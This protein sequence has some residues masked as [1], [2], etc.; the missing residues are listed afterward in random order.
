[1]VRGVAD[2]WALEPI[3]SLRLGERDYAI[4]PLTFARF[5]RLL[6]LDAPGLV[7]GMAGGDIAAAWPW[8]E[9]CMPGITRAEWEEHATKATVALAVLAFAKAHDWEFIGEAI[10]FGE[11]QEPGEKLPTQIDVTSGLLA[12]AKQSG[13]RIED[14]LAMRP[15]GF[16]LIVES[17][18]QQTEDARPRETNATMPPGIGVETDPEAVAK[19]N[20]LLEGATDG[21]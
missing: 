21:D 4:P 9:V 2:A 5:Q 19:M 10:R 3:G 1:M 17:I 13:H 8:A 20:A 11:P 6:G 12:V 15:E 7:Q 18:R 16:Y 14:L